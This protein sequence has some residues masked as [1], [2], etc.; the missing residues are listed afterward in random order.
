M[1]S[2]LAAIFNLPSY[3]YLSLLRTVDSIGNMC[4]TSRQEATTSIN[5]YTVHIEKVIGSRNTVCMFYKSKVQCILHI[6]YIFACKNLKN[7]A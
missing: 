2:V 7:Y 5:M 6:G 4:S 1:M 3:Q